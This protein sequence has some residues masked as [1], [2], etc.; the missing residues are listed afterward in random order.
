MTNLQRFLSACTACCALTLLPACTSTATKEAIKANDAY[1]NYCK[2]AAGQKIYKT[3]Q[4]VDA[5]FLEKVPDKPN[6]TELS[7]RFYLDAAFGEERWGIF[8][9]GAFIRE[10]RTDDSI[11]TEKETIAGKLYTNNWKIWPKDT[12]GYKFV[13]AYE[14]KTLYDYTKYHAEVPGS[15]FK[16][17]RDVTLKKRPST[18]M[19]RYK[20][21]YEHQ[22]N[23]DDRRMGIASN[24]LRV[25]DTQNGELLG[26]YVR[27]V[28]ARN[29]FSSGRSGPAWAAQNICGS[30][31]PSDPYTKTF[32]QRVLIPS[33]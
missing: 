18:G 25:I 11:N 24:T 27:Y 4:N 28:Q 5:V 15:P 19:V 31:D 2:T 22:L 7:D 12:P 1:L 17:L 8:Y 21:T 14:G 10:Y 20:V 26:E 9:T 16:E 23:R 30:Q 13:Q 3:V 33:N 29:S 32:V 6:D